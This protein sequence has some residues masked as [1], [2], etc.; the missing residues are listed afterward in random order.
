MAGAVTVLGLINFSALM[1]SDFFD[2][3]AYQQLT[4]EQATAIMRDA[5][6]P[7]MIFAWQIPGMAGS[8]LGLVAVAAA[9]ARAG[10]AG[11]WFPAGV[12]SGMVIWIGGTR[13]GNQLV[14]YAG[15]A[16]LLLVFGVVGIA[17]IRMTDE[18]WRRP[19]G[20]RSR[21]ERC[22]RPGRN[23]APVTGDG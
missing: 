12:L 2:I 20:R 16:I 8:F 19:P 18:R 3:V 4:V 6:Q 17:M 13:A 14:S 11:W 1:I 10:H 7:A 15:P 9:Y 5:A 22:E 21:R 23:H